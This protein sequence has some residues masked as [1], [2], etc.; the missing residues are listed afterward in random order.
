MKKTSLAAL[1]ILTASI[2]LADGTVEQ[3]SQ[4]Q[5]SGPLGGLVNV[6]SRTAREGVTST[7][8]IS[9]NRK[10]TRT[11]DAGELVD[12][13]QEK[14][15]TIDFKRQTY[16]VK[17]FA[18]LRREWEKQQK[19]VAENARE[20]KKEKNEGPEY[21]IDFDVKSTGKKETING[22]NTHQ[23]IVTV[24]VREKGKKLEQSGGFV[25]T[26]DMWMGPKIAAVNDQAD[27]DRRFVQK[28]YGPTFAAD[29]RQL[30]M[31]LAMSP[32]FGK[33]MKTFYDKRGNLDGTAVLT[34][35]KF[36]TVAGSEPSK[37]QARSEER[38]SEPTSV[39]GAVIGGLFNK[40]KKRQADKNGEPAEPATPGR[41][42][43][44][45]STLELTRATSSASAAD[46]AIPAGFTQR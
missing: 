33:A 27:F 45:N 39:S 21:E 6:F 35:M 32:A 24:T 44:F 14:V 2:C 41:S 30:A 20:S 40:M 23:E 26:S 4:F 15:Y 5:L 17:T 3:K 42:S 38:E 31:A 11:G 16:A 1:A 34:K 36:E 29:M 12:L 28:V 18:D 46:V 22:W 19:E 9:K 13:D 25:L 37:E 8:S 7:T 43:M 10:L